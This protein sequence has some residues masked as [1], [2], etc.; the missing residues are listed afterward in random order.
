MNDVSTQPNG[1]V[2]V[3]LEGVD[4]KQ[5]APICSRSDQAEVVSWTTEQEAKVLDRGNISNALTDT[6]TQ[7]LGIT[8][9]DVNLGNQ[10]MLAGIVV[11]EL[12]SNMLLQK[13]GAPVWLT[14]QMGIWG[15]IALTQTW[16]TNKSSFF[17]TRFILGVFEG[18]YV[19]GGQYMLSLFYTRE[20]LATRTAVFYFGNYFAAATGS[21]MAAG[22]LKLA[23]TNGLS[24]WQWLHTKPIHCYFDCFSEKKRSILSARMSAQN[25]ADKADLSWTKVKGALL[26][27][28]LWLHMIINMASL[29]PKGGLQLYGPSVIKGLGFSKTRANA[30]NS[31]SSYLVVV[32]SFAISYASDKTHQRGLWCIVAFAWS[33]AFSGALY[34][35]PLNANR[36]TRFWIFTFLGSGNALAQGL[37][38]AWVSANAQTSA[39]RSIGLAL[40][41]MGSNLGGLAGQQMFRQSDAPRYQRGFLAILC[42]YVGSIVLT[43]ATI[44][45]YWWTNKK[46]KREYQER[47]SRDDVGDVTETGPFKCQL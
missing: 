43:V 10:L 30:L 13:V 24:G 28:R 37:N 1:S 47:E 3:P 11:A 25:N 17:A 42:L 20:E 31:I 32:F 8:N 45:A 27:F 41:V 36:W 12:P 29:A 44:A 23:G 22:I 18:G 14:G 5:L 33:I 34:G 26:D 21:L 35:L 7:D 40:A 9:D 39:G 46:L 15:T 6:I 38:D 19:P 2:S 4:E 16:V